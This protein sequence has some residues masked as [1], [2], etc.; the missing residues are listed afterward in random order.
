MDGSCCIDDSVDCVVS[1]ERGEMA[2]TEGAAAEL[3]RA[4]MH[5]DVVCVGMRRRSMFRR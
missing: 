1:V 3:E 2:A 5:N 4:E